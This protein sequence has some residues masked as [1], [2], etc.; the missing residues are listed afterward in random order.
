MHLLLILAPTFIV[1]VLAH[2]EIKARTKEAFQRGL[3]EG[4]EQAW[5]ETR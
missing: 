2:I 4:R 3:R 5:K 1:G